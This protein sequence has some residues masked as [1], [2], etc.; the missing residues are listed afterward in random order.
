MSFKVNQ[1]HYNYGC[2]PT[3]ERNEEDIERFFIFSFQIYFI[4]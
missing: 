2:I 3:T 1:S 4:F